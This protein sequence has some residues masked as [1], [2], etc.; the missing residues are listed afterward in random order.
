MA[1]SW[2]EIQRAIAQLEAQMT[3]QATTSPSA[4]FGWAGTDEIIEITWNPE[5][6]GSAHV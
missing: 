6:V 4:I 3:A 5:T 2:Q 1:A